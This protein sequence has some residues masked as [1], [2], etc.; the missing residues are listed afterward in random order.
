MSRQTTDLHLAGF[1]R[2]DLIRAGAPLPRPQHVRDAD[3]KQRGD[4]AC[5]HPSITC[6]Q[7][8]LSQVLQISLPSDPIHRRL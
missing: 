3:L 8:P 4:S 6:R 5:R 2:A 7:N 1:E